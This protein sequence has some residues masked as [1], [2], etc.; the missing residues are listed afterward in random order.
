MQSL[1]EPGAQA[2][3]KARTSVPGQLAPTFHETEGKQR[4][5]RFQAVLTAAGETKVQAKPPWS[6]MQ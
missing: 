4:V 6:S 2:S 5:G 1:R 3:G